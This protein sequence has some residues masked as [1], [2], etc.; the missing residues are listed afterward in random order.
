MT[1]SS[2]VSFLE[3]ADPTTDKPEPARIQVL[4]TDPYGNPA[5]N[6]PIIFGILSNDFPGWQDNDVRKTDANGVA[7]LEY[8]PPALPPDDTWTASFTFFAE[9]WGY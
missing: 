6:R 9:F 5:P 3:W 8:P 4:L 1:L 7:I 2:P